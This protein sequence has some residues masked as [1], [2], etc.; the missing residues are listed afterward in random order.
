MRLLIKYEGTLTEIS[1]VPEEWILITPGSSI[2][3]LEQFLYGKYPKLAKANYTIS[4]NNSPV[5]DKSVKTNTGDSI[6]FMS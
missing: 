5:A 4:I 1:H 2:A 6:S 3:E